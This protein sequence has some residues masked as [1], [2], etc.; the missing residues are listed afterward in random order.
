[1]IEKYK[2]EFK[3][4]GLNVCDVAITKPLIA[5]TG[6][7][8]F[9]VS[10]TANW[11]EKQVAILVYSVT[12][13]GKKIVEHGTLLIKFFDC[14]AAHLEWKRHAYLIKRSIERLQES[15]E[16]GDAHRMKRGMVYKLFAALV[17]Y[18]DNFRSIR[19]VVLDSDQNEA[20]IGRA[21]V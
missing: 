19:E 7:E 12:P 10:A 4:V 9:R 17:D 16:T 11:A 14:E 18:D 1:M 13:E 15:A 5:K 20:K 6:E 21:H 2:P 8:N 3:G